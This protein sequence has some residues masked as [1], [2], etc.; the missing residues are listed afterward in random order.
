MCNQA[1]L[2]FARE[3]LSYDSLMALEAIDTHRI[4]LAPDIGFQ[5]RPAPEEEASEILA[6]HCLRE[7]GEPVVALTPNM[8]IYERQEG[9]GRRNAYV[10][11][12]A[13]IVQWFQHELGARVVLIPHEIWGDRPDDVR[14]CQ[15]L[16]QEAPY[17]DRICMLSSG[18]TAAQIKAI[19]GQADFL[20]AS[21]YHSLVAAF[22][23]RV[24]VAVV[25]WSHKYD[26]LMETAQ[27]RDWCADPVRRDSEG[28]LH[29][30][31]RAW[32]RRDEIRA[33]LQAALPKLEDQSRRSLQ[34]MVEQILE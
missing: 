2:V 16:L 24:P 23:M 14:L 19:I 27:L 21:R 28:V 34:M 22:S 7:D 18:T 26:E 12:F 9:K 31:R 6:C 33:S 13:D 30:I 3:K 17:A 20:V 8:R 15:F 5:F 11:V 29:M 25:G 1:D 32:D 10:H 4:H